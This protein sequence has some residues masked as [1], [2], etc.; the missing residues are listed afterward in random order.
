[1]CWIRENKELKWYE[2]IA[3]YDDDLCIATKDP[4]QIIQIIKE[5]FKLKDKGDEPLVTTY[6][7]TTPG[8]RTIL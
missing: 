6:V 5:D 4:G 2:H 3:T 7:Q 8:T 1:M